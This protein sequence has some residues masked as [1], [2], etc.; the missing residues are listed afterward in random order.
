LVAEIKLYNEGEVNE[1][2]RNADLYHRLKKEIDRKR[3][4]YEMR[5]SPLVT[6]KFDYFYEELVKTLAGGDAS[7]LGPGWEE[8]RRKS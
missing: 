3:K 4:V 1:G 2:R 8:S 5:V 6:A 7:N